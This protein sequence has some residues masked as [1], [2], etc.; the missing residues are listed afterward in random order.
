MSEEQDFQLPRTSAE[1]RRLIWAAL[2]RRLETRRRARVPLGSTNQVPL[3]Y[4]ARGR[5]QAVNTRRLGDTT[6]D[7]DG[8]GLL[9]DMLE[10]WPDN[11][12]DF[13]DALPLVLAEAYELIRTGLLRPHP[14]TNALFITD[15]GAR[16]LDD[17][18]PLHPLDTTAR[19]DA[20]SLEFADSPHRELMA[21]YLSVAI[22][23]HR[24]NLP[25]A[26]ATMIGC[27]YELALLELA[28]AV[29]ARWVDAT[30]IP[31]LDGDEKQAMKRLAEGSPAKIS[32]VE[33]AVFK[34]LEH[35][36][37]A[38]R[39]HWDWA[40]AGFRA[41]F[42]LVRKLRNSAG[43]PTGARVAADDVWTH[44]LLMPGWYRHVRGII[45][46]LQGLGP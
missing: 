15:H 30:R 5:F 4:P 1:V 17:G 6:L 20:F 46:L 36:R 39:D 29:Q 34:A 42:V 44:I 28:G 8:R 10:V 35:D 37:A 38:M 26:G 7:M 31:G 27:A 13:A 16:C 3:E 12:R 9:G 14:G 40:E 24:A 43:H 21:R 11:L 33:G 45:G 25:L 22:E 23:A 32:K 19:V 18:D 2:E 41:T